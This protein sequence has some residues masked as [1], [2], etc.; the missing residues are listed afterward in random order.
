MRR[1]K[2]PEGA[3]SMLRALGA[4]R[5]GLI[6][7]NAFELRTREDWT[8]IAK[9]LH[10]KWPLPPSVSVDDVRQELLLAI[11]V[12]KRSSGMKNLLEKWQPK[13]RGKPSRPLDEYIVWNA[14]VQ[15]SR[16]IH[17]QRGAKRNRENGDVAGKIRGSFLPV[18]SSVEKVSDRSDTVRIEVPVAALQEQAAIL[19][20]A[21]RRVRANAY[22]DKAT[23]DVAALLLTGQG[24]IASRTEKRTEGLGEPSKGGM[25]SPSRK[26][27]RERT[28]MLNGKTRE[29]WAS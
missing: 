22:E 19:G 14:K 16:W 29:S 13:R 17:A 26:S 9:A 23:R 20:E 25:V 11:V 1:Q 7:F 2:Y 4:L 18:L 8:R 21:L 12:R 5:M 24:E 3:S 28:R 27:E 6:S 15:A 10:A